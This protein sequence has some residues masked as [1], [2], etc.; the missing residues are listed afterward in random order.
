[1]T[2]SDLVSVTVLVK[3][4]GRRCCPVP[5]SV[6]LASYPDLTRAAW[7]RVRGQDDS[8]TNITKSS[9]YQYCDNCCFQ[10]TCYSH[11]LVILWVP[12]LWV[13]IP[14]MS[15]SSVSLSTASLLIIVKMGKLGKN[16]GWMWLF[17]TILIE[18]GLCL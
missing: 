18:G 6:Q 17:L 9:G 1:M 3:H 16:S 11:M 2:A 15:C 10:G 5:E 4:I 7:D 14:G 12:A 13:Q 8:H